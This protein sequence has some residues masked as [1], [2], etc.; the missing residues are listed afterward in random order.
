MFD[1]AFTGGKTMIAY[2]TLTIAV[3]GQG[4][5]CSAARSVAEKLRQRLF[6]VSRP[7]PTADFYRRASSL[8]CLSAP[9]TSLRRVE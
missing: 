9:V 5:I 7:R 8:V 1:A 6:A 3:D 4:T 2:H